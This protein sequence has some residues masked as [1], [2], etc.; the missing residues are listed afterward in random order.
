[1]LNGEVYLIFN[2][3]VFSRINTEAATTGKGMNFL[4]TFYSVIPLLTRGCFKFHLNAFEYIIISLQITV[5]DTI[6]KH[7]FQH[8]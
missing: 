4:K 6:C 1:M 5:I 7:F 8:V 3:V 2:T